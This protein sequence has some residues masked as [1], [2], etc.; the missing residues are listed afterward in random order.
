MLTKVFGSEESPPSK[1]G[2]QPISRMNQPLLGFLTAAQEEGWTTCTSVLTNRSRFADAFPVATTT[3]RDQGRI[4][5]DH[6]VTPAVSPSPNR[7]PVAVRVTGMT[8]VVIG[9][10]TTNVPA[11]WHGF[12]LGKNVPANQLISASGAAFVRINAEAADPPQVAARPVRPTFS[13][14]NRSQPRPHHAHRRLKMQHSHPADQARLSLPSLV[15]R[16]TAP[17]LQHH[18]EAVLELRS[19]R[20]R[21]REAADLLHAVPAHGTTAPVSTTEP[22]GCSATAGTDQSCHQRL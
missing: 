4:F 15:Q 6:G 19:A 17:A 2:V 7:R 5:I 20:V 11:A 14:K 1:H 3:T 12:V 21:Q 10:V 9:I 22:Q 16:P 18:P 8:P 13:R